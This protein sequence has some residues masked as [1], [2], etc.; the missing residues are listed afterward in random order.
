MYIRRE[1][2]PVELSDT[3]MR[4]IGEIE[5]IG[6]HEVDKQREQNLIKLC[7]TIDC[8]L[9][10]IIE[11][12]PYKNRPEAS[13][14]DIGKYASGWLADKCVWIRDYFDEFVD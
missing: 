7:S 9:D 11:L 10:E 6:S 4:I 1:L 14:R 12:V 13:V 2:D 5:P 8:L 3:L